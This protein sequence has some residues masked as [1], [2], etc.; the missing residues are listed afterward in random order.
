[1][2]MYGLFW[3]EYLN[4]LCPADETLLFVKSN[5]TKSDGG[6][7]DMLSR[8]KCGTVFPLRHDSHGTRNSL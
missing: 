8:P 7:Y 6:S 1:M 3:D 5:N 4:P 2:R